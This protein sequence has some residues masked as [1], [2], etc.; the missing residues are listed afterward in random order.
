MINLGP[1]KSAHQRFMKEAERAV[2]DVA[3]AAANMGAQIA[4]SGLQSHVRTGKML[5]TT[6]GSVVRR[7]LN[8]VIKLT[9]DAKYAPYFEF[10]TVPHPIVARRA[11]YLRFP[12]ASGNIIFRKRVFHPGNKAFLVFAAAHNRSSLF[13]GN[14]LRI[15]MEALARTF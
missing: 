3:E 4:K 13:A 6:R 11:R 8:R 7:G 2:N 9:N 12:D 14:A 15:R 10:G 5:K 1:L